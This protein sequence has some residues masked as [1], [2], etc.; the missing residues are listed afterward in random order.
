[1]NSEDQPFD[2]WLPTLDLFAPDFDSM[3]LSHFNGTSA[4]GQTSLHNPNTDRSRTSETR[5]PLTLDGTLDFSCQLFGFT[6]ESD[7][8][9]LSRLPSDTNGELKYF[10]LVYRNMFNEDVRGGPGIPR[11]R[12]PVH[13]LCSHRETV[14]NAR[15]MVDS[16]LFGESTVE[17]DRDLLHK[18]VNADLG[19]A[20]ISL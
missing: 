13:F 9:L 7:P 10:R 11:A 14:T 12:A 18:M 5:R 17:R 2:G 19:V 16:A 4:F 8:F 6:N 1:M 3:Q 20:L 15:E